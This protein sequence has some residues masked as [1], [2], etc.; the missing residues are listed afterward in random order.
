MFYKTDDLKNFA[1]LTGRAICKT[2]SELQ[3]SQQIDTK[4]QASD[5]V[6]LNP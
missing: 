4:S 1:Q 6:T 3:Q 5:T 2:F